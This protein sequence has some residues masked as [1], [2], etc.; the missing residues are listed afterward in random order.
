MP[1]KEIEESDVTI[2]NMPKPSGCLPAA[3]WQKSMSDGITLMLAARPRVHIGIELSL[4][5]NH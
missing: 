4:C 1:I 3:G 5:A 2:Q